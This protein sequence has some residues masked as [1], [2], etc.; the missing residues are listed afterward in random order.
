M[1]KRVLF[2]A[3]HPDDE[4]L[5]CGGTIFRHLQDGDDI[6]WLII[7]NI[8]TDTEELSR[9]RNKRDKEIEQVAKEYCFTDTYKLDYPT[10]KLDEL[11]FSDIIESVSSVVCEVQPHTIYVNNRSDIHT[12]HQIVFKAIISCSKSFRYPFVKRIL[13][14]ETLSETENI[15]SLH[16]DIFIPNV[17]IDITKYIDMKI[18]IIN[19]YESEVME[20]PQPRSINSLKALASY[21]GTRIQTLY[22][23]AFQLLFESI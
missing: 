9:R 16:E 8:S 13:M 18:K 17:F 21:R 22:A 10:T 23:E 14:Y 2:V 6:F 15:P 11:P 12:D 19:L 3:P 1:N 4:T 20:T 7:T 5:G